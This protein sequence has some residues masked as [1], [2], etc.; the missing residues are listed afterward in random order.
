MTARGFGSA[1]NA[2]RKVAFVSGLFAAAWQGTHCSRI[3]FRSF[4]LAEIRQRRRLRLSGGRSRQALLSQP[5]ETRWKQA[6]EC[7]ADRGDQGPGGD[8]AIT[9]AG[10]F[11]IVARRCEEGRVIDRPVEARRHRVELTAALRRFIGARDRALYGRYM[12]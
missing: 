6:G 7:G 1:K 10:K 12:S 5:E 4:S 2:S 11:S 8:E 9:Q 3:S